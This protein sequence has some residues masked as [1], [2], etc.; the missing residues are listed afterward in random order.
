MLLY[1]G[2]NTHENQVDS[3]CEWIQRLELDLITFQ[4]LENRVASKCRNTVV[5]IL[6]DQNSG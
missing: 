1:F 4:N 6:D 2:W 3:G 5:E